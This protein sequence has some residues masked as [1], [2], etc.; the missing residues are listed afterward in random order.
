MIDR[1]RVALNRIISPRWPLE[2]FLRFTAGQGLSAVELRNDLPGGRV[3]DGLTPEE[4]R[5]LIRRYRL[6]VLTINALQHFNLPQGERERVKELGELA[7]LARALDRP[8]LVLCPHND[9]ADRRSG[10]ERLRDTVRA[11]KELAPVLQQ[12]GLSGLVEP[13]GFAESSL[14]SALTAQEAI[15]ESGRGE[16][17]IVFDTFHHF[18]G[19][20]R[21]E[22]LEGRLRVELIGLVHLSGISEGR[23]AAELR[24]PQRI[25]PDSRDRMDTRG[26]LAW[27]DARGYR[28]PL[29]FEPF[30]PEVQALEPDALAARL[31]ESLAWLG[32]AA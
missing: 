3:I 32:V 27:L 22:G 25:L 5:E 6:R 11:L 28:G 13:L 30:S 15:L 17:R 4:A 20:D 10:P 21:L 9:P 26:Q 7:R 31:R 1:A 19:P 14:A 24:D 18:L 8:A 12:H 23:P 16:Y 29:S 2:E